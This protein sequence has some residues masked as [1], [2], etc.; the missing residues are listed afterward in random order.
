MRIGIDKINISK[1][2]IDLKVIRKVFILDK[3]NDFLLYLQP[4]FVSLL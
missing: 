1:G 2:R 3:Q 4:L